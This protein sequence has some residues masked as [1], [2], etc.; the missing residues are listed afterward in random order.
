[1]KQVG[2]I[3]QNVITLLGLTIAP[4]IPICIGNTNIDH[5]KASHPEDFAKYFCEIEN[6]LANPDYVIPNPKDKGSLQYIKNLDVKVMV[7]IRPS[8]SG[9]F[10][11]R[12]VY[13]VG[14]QEE[15]LAKAGLFEKYKLT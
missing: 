8:G 12:S 15:R 14:D 7:P 3:K 6:I 10:F 11:A 13:C 1:M 4:G 9:K 5:M 2:Q